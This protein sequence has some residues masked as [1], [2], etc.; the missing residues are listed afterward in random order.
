MDK[1]EPQQ[2]GVRFLKQLGLWGSVRDTLPTMEME[3][4]SITLG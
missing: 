3:S 2:A 4:H 1:N